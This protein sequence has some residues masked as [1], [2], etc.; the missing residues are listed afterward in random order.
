MLQ[1]DKCST[2]D[3]CTIKIL[4]LQLENEKLKNKILLSDTSVKKLQKN[5]PLL[6]PLISSCSI[7]SIP[8][9][10]TEDYIDQIFKNIETSRQYIQKLDEIKEYRRKMFGK[11][12]IFKY[13]EL[14]QL[15]NLRLQKIAEVKN[16]DKRKTKEIISR[17]LTSLESRLIL[18]EGYTSS[19]ID[20]DDLKKFEKSIELLYPETECV[21]FKHQDFLKNFKTYGLAVMDIKD[22]FEKMTVRTNGCW[23]VIY[24]PIAKSSLD[25]PYS[26]YY[27]DKIDKDKDKRH[28]K[29]ICRLEDLS[30]DI[31]DS[32]VP[33]CIQLARQI[34]RDV[35]ND[36]SYRRDFSAKSTILNSEFLQLL[37]NIR[38][39]SNPIKFCK[40]LQS[41]VIGSCTYT[42]NEKDKFNLSADD[43]VQQKKFNVVDKHDNSVFANTIHQLFDDIQ[44]NEIE[45][46]LTKFEI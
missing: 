22:Y 13:I 1:C 33:F 4:E 8:E 19:T 29:M 28:W 18:F 15:H 14:I 32:T 17:T 27:L 2:C 12:N 7:Q 21:P 43:K 16:H 20:I 26:F 10:E 34:Y 36:N 41:V 45:H 23:N 31:I 6:T 25:D 5:S 39:M 40:T 46:C 42:S 24:L 3:K 44:P 37:H 11:I 35:F 38:A 30:N 9:L